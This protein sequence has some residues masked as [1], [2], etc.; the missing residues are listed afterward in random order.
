MRPGPEARLPEAVVLARLVNE[1]G[2]E[3]VAR[4]FAVSHDAVSAR[5][6]RAG[7]RSALRGTCYPRYVRDDEPPASRPASR[8][9]DEAACA[10]VDPEL[11]FP[12]GLRGESG[13]Y[14]AQVRE[15]K[16]ICA[17]CP[18][19]GA[20]LDD[21]LASGMDHGIWG[22]MTEDERKLLRKPRS[23]V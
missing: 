11:F 10:S 2:T 9:W 3:H 8:W 1:H 17:H 12:L 18:V 19:R 22:G 5:L 7:F 6:L 4:S 15:V 14:E 23:R 16:A 21:A 13:S 20:C